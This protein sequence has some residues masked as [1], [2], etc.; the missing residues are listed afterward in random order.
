M[1]TDGLFVISFIHM[2]ENTSKPLQSLLGRGIRV[3]AHMIGKDAV[4]SER[5]AIHIL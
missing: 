4:R 5:V 1:F 2:P 3:G